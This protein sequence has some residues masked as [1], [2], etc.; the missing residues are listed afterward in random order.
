MRKDILYLVVGAF[1][2][3]GLLFKFM[4]WQGAGIILSTS[5]FA[6]T[7]ALVDF[8]IYNRKAT[9]FKRKLFYPLLGVVYVLGLLF[10]I[11]H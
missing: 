6:T 11:M 2:A 8:A 7:I 1:L 3:I 5:L 9:S 10:K 4:H